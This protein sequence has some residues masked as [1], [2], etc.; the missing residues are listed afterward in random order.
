MFF[1][2]S[3]IF[4]NT[5][6]LKRTQMIRAAGCSLAQWVERVSRVQRLCPPCSGP[7]FQSQ[8]W[9]EMSPGVLK[10]GRTAIITDESKMKIT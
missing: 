3:V 1:P 2:F 10:H 4:T 9:L 7:G 8:T 6:E 5:H